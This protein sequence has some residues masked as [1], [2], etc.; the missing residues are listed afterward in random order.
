MGAIAALTGVPDDLHRCE[1]P[2]N[3][4]QWTQLLAHAAKVPSQVVQSTFV[5]AELRYLRQRGSRQYVS[6]FV[7]TNET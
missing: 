1:P 5:V 2:I 7:S 4:I 3:A 6:A